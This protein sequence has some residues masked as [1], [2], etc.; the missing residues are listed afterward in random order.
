MLD[1]D[2]EAIARARA[3]EIFGALDLHAKAR[4]RSGQGLEEHEPDVARCI[5]HRARAWFAALWTRIEAGTSSPA[6][7]LDAIEL[8]IQARGGFAD[9]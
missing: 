6:E 8:R 9:Q 7:D 4:A 3:D 1:H 5:E 2:A